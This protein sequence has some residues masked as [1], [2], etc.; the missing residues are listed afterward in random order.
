MSVAQLYSLSLSLSLCIDKLTLE[1]IQ[2]DRLGASFTNDYF[3]LFILL[4]ADDVVLLSE[5]GVG[6]RTQLNTLQS[7]ASFLQLHSPDVILCG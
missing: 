4:L 3:E 2:N 6:L 7:S 5:R 1:G